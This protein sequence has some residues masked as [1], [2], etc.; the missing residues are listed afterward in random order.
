MKT[1]FFLCPLL[2][3]AGSAFAVSPG[4]AAG[5]AEA[6][7]YSPAYNQCMDKAMSTAA[8][9]DCAQQE[10]GKQDALLNKAYKAQM[11]K[12]SDPRKQQLL[13]A[14]RA[15]LKYRETQTAFLYD[16]DGGSMARIDSELEFLRITAERARFLRTYG[17]EGS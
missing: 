14:Q 13:A 11:E 16:P 12:L 3:L 7:L 9:L 15:W 4:P 17:E 6:P 10:L 1:L 2:L 8:M 5:Q